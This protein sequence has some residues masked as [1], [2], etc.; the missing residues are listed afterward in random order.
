MSYTYSRN[1]WTISQIYE[2]YKTR[3]LDLE[4]EIQRSYVWDQARRAKFIESLLLG[5][6]IP[7]IYVHHTIRDYETN[8]EGLDYFRPAGLLDV[9]PREGHTPGF[10][11]YKQDAY[12][13]LDG[14]QRLSTIIKFIEGK[15]SLIGIDAIKMTDIYGQEQTYKVRGGLMLSLPEELRKRLEGTT[16]D[17]IE[18][19]NMTKPE[20]REFF[21]RINSGRPL[22]VRNKA[23]I[24]C[25]NL[26]E[27]LPMQS[28]RIFEVMYGVKA[29]D[30][31]NITTLLKCWTVLNEEHPRLTATWYKHISEINMTREQIDELDEILDLTA[32]AV[33]NLSVDYRNPKLENETHLTSLMP[34]MREALKDGIDPEYIAGFLHFF[35]EPSP[36][37]DDYMKH[38]KRDS[39]TEAHTEARANILLD[40]Y[41]KYFQKE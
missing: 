11:I 27:L 1:F 10:R 41:R 32:E 5:I 34:V 16:L 26:E 8:D 39:A 31:D 25:N 9:E 12:E 7:P 6:P 2:L 15:V 21:R 13:V 3:R 33:E 40:A 4:H 37:L 28:K 24:D 30:K 38:N 29:A 17:V 18:F 14:K 36:E 22:S 23:L 20:S 35:S 19:T